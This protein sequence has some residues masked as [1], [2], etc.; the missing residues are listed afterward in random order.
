MD[1]IEKAIQDLEK[2]INVLK[3]FSL[4]LS[5]ENIALVRLICRHLNIDE[6]KFVNEWKE[7]SKSSFMEFKDLEGLEKQINE[8]FKKDQNG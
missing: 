7:L 8:I 3:D 2:K 1:N 6:E 4:Q 5:T